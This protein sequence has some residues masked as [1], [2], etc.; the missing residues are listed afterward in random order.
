MGLGSR[1]SDLAQRL[2]MFQD[3][4]VLGF[5]VQ[6]WRSVSGSR[7]GEVRGLEEGFS[8]VEGFHFV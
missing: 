6:D 5:R 1:A 2:G 3:F 4:R 7:K 8:I